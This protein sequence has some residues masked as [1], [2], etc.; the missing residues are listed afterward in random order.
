MKAVILAGGYGTRISEETD[1]K[2]KPMIEIGG[3]PLLWHIMKIYARHGVREFIICLG[4]KGHVIKQF[5]LDYRVNV[6]DLTIETAT[7]AVSFNKTVDDWRVSLVETGLH[8]MTGGRLKQVRDYIGSDDFF[9]TYGD[10]VADIDIGRLLAFHQAEKRLATVTAVAPPGRFGALRLDDG[11]VAEFMEKPA[12]DGF[13]ING[14][15]FVLSPKVMDYIESDA[16]AWE[17]EPLERLAT[18]GQLSAYQHDGFWHSVDTIR[19]K[20]Q[21]ESLW[22]SG[23]APW[24]TQ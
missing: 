5:F 1:N 3:R 6:S 18:E 12:G 10:G 17:R 22:S 24:A 2:P 20:A 9:L 13:R 14:G 11:R 8:S 4:Y 21:L 23:K 19:D 7:G 16:T 15:F